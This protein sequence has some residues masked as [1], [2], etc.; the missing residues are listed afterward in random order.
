MQLRLPPL[1]GD[2][3]K[4]NENSSVY[5]MLIT[6]ANDTESLRYIS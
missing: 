5:N 6:L 1:H 4:I 2:D 3:G